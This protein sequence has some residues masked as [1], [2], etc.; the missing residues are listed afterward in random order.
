MFKNMVKAQILDPVIGRVDSLVT[1]F[2]LGFGRHG[3]RVA[4]FA[5]RRVIGTGVATF[6]VDETNV[7]V[8]SPDVSK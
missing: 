5:C 6:G 2:H 4:I 8:L 3:C 7:A 1:V